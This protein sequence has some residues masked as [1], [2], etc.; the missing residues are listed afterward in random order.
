MIYVFSP[1]LR[2]PCNVTGAMK[3]PAG[4][5]A[6][7]ALARPAVAAWPWSSSHP[8]AGVFIGAEQHVFSA[9]AL[10]LLGLVGVTGRCS[11][12][13]VVDEGGKGFC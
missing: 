5:C 7:S 8:L 6:D 2:E 1:L 9:R 13:G 3:P 10:H 4:R 11:D 12:A